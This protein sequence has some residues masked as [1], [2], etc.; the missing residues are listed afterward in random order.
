MRIMVFLFKNWFSLSKLFYFLRTSSCFN[1]AVRLEKY[2]KTVCDGLSKVCKVIFDDISS[3][4]L[5]LPAEMV[6]GFQPHHY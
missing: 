1:H 6:L 2:D 5:A 4:Q 3:T